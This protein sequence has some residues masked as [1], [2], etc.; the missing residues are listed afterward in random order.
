[1][2]SE[3]NMEKECKMNFESLEFLAHKSPYG[4]E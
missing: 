4:M 3:K 2:E 1:M